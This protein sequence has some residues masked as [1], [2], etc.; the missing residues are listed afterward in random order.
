MH[1]QSLDQAIGSLREIPKTYSPGFPLVPFD[2]A[3]FLADRFL[4]HDVDNNYE[5]AKVLLDHLLFPFPLWTL[6]AHTVF[7]LLAK[8]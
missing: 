7:K 3:N 5:E 4:V 1:N 6:R 2:L 8:H